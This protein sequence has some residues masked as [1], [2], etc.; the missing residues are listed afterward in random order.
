MAGERAQRRLAAILAADVVGY[1]RLMEQDE[2]GTLSTLKE[3]RK[4]ILQPL[5][6][7]YGGRIVKVMGD[8]VLVE[9]ASA[10][11]AVACAVE[12]QKRMASANASLSDDR[13]IV[14]RIGINLGDVMVEGSDLYGDGVNIAARLEG[15]AEPSGIV[16]SGTTHDYVKNKVDVGFDDLGPQTLK[17]I[18][19]PVRVYRV[20]NTGRVPTAMR[21]AATDKPSIAVLPFVNI[22]GDMEQSYFSDGITEDIITELSRFQ[23]LNV[24]A[25]ST[26]FRYRGAAV[27]IQQVG[28]DLG[29]R[30]VLEGSIR[31]STDRVRITAQLINVLD[32]NHLWAERYDRNISDLFAIQDELVRTIV[33]SLAGRLASDLTARA[34]EKPTTSLAAYDYVLRAKAA[35]EE[36]YYSAGSFFQTGTES[37]R[38][39][40]KDA[41]KLDPEYGLACSYLGFSYFID[42]NYLGN[43]SDVEE[44]YRHAKRGATLNPNDYRT[45]LWF[46]NICLV[47]KDYEKGASHIQR[48]IAM[49]PNDPEVIAALGLYQDLTGDHEGSIVTLTKALELSPFDR[50]WLFEQLGI[51]LYCSRSYAQAI[52]AFKRMTNAPHWTHAHMAAAYGQLG[53]LEEARGE[54]RKFMNLHP[55]E[56]ERKTP[57][58]VE[59][60]NVPRAL[61]GYV[62]EYKKS[63]DFQHW[64]DG[65]R[66][67]GLPV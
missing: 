62:R 2:A 4:G 34:R 55:W 23:S 49:N 63:D 21:K 61:I 59:F 48:A 19:E 40:L 32:A 10:V 5:V 65:W 33:A 36:A 27:D 12:L 22:G 41:L 47:A 25:R 56:H 9:F 16:I 39:M 8:G 20:A 53:R 6:T 35:L 26:S 15:I 67:A 57:P 64:I 44:A 43:P 29:V 37:A 3:R 66:K 28:R 18:A 52:D 13:Q 30:Y 7:E 45:H 31:K 51:S 17:N 1:S 50:D 42:F 11:N 38:E 14:L 24:I 46:G 60:P 58:D 54:A